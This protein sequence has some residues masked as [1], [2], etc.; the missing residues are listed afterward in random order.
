M[1]TLEQ[2]QI[3][4]ANEIEQKAIAIGD[5]KKQLTRRLLDARYCLKDEYRKLFKKKKVDFKHK[6]ML[7]D[8]GKYVLI[9]RI[10][11]YPDEP[12]SYNNQQTSNGT[13]ALFKVRD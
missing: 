7:S 4:T 9:W 8:C 11:E 2:I 10:R 5:D 12:E 3:E 1:K 6:S 13:V